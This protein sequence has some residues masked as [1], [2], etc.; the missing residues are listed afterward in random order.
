MLLDTWNFYCDCVR[1]EF[2]GINDEDDDEDEGDEITEDHIDDVSINDDNTLKT[3][4]KMDDDLK[5]KFRTSSAWDLEVGAWGIAY[6]QSI[7]E[8]LVNSWNWKESCKINDRNQIMSRLL[9]RWNKIE[10]TAQI[11]LITKPNGLASLLTQII[12]TSLKR[13]GI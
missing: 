11:F 13:K 6:K 4:K 2:A 8:H 7:V 10:E 1:C 12:D 5:I 3:F 9:E